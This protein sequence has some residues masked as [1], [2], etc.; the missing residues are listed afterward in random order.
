[1]PPE[2]LLTRLAELVGD[3]KEI[4]E[5]RRILKKYPKLV[6]F[7]EGIGTNLMLAASF[8]HVEMCKMLVRLGADVNHVTSDTGFESTDT[9]V[10]SAI[11]GG[12]VEALAFLLKAGARPIEK[13]RVVLTAVNRSHDSGTALKLIRLLEKAGCDLHRIFLHQNTGE[14]MN[15]LSQAE[16]NNHKNVVAYLEKRG[17]KRPGNA[18][19][20]ERLLKIFSFGK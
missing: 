8:N 2:K 1:M 15:A 5:V 16:S 6:D 20:F 4:E 11:N 14:R 3:G 17:V 9:P 18:S 19:V 7:D 13:N 12:S 10:D